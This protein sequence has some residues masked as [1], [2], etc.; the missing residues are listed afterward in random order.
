MHAY[1]YLVI[2]IRYETYI[3]T[4]IY[5]VQFHN[6]MHSLPLQQLCQIL[7]LVHI[8]RCVEVDTKLFACHAIKTVMYCDKVELQWSVK[9]VCTVT[10]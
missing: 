9:Y 1:S 2:H 6:M 4:N 8:S 3:H 10:E 5:T 7:A